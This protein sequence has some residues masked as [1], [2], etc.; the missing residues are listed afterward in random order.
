MYF[1]F[2]SANFGKRSSKH[3]GDGALTPFSIL[4]FSNLPESCQKLDCYCDCNTSLLGWSCA[5]PAK[6]ALDPRKQPLNGIR[7]DAHTIFAH[8]QSQ[9]SHRQHNLQVS[10]LRQGGESCSR[11]PS[12]QHDK[13]GGGVGARNRCN[14][15]NWR[16]NLETVHILAILKGLLGFHP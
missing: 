6:Q 12:T 15:A 8:P 9:P 10:F 5:V 13:W 4:E 11:Q 14:V 2:S 3:I 1:V 7:A 16:S